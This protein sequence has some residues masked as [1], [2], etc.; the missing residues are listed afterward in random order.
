VNL[1]PR[2]SIEPEDDRRLRAGR[3]ELYDPV[4]VIGGGVIDIQAEPQFLVEAPWPDRPVVFSGDGEEWPLA[5][6]GSARNA[7]TI[8]ANSRG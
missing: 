2:R 1:L 6:K 3:S 8:A 4:V 5:G 7:L